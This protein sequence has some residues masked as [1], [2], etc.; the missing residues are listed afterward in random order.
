MVKKLEVRRTVTLR[1]T[2]RKRSQRR[3]LTISNASSAPIW[4]T[5][6]L[7]AQAR[8]R[9]QEGQ[10]DQIKKLCAL[11]ARTRAI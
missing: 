9:G 11:D 1:S 4:V 8:L 7:C 10:E 2:R 6:H 5:M 3:I